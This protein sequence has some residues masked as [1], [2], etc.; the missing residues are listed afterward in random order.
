MESPLS[1][2]EAAARRSRS[3]GGGRL[4]LEGL[5]RKRRRIMSE[6]RST[7]RM[8]ACWKRIGK[9]DKVMDRR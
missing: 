1:A 4:L 3:V 5:E 6:S 8:V 7:L 9:G 2:A